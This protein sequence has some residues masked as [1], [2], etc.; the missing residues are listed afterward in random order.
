MKIKINIE[1]WDSTTQEKFYKCGLTNDTVKNLYEVAF[2]NILNK[3]MTS[4]VNYS[5]DVEVT[6]E[7][8]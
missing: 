8:N 5:L 1:I 7:V 6:D 3:M 4:G 2:K